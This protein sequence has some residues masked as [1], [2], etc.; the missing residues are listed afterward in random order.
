MENKDKQQKTYYQTIITTQQLLDNLYNTDWL[1]LDC[2]GAVVSDSCAFQAYTKD[3]IP[4][5][6]YC[7]INN[8]DD[9]S[10]ATKRFHIDDFFEET[11]VSTELMEHGFNKNSQIIIYDDTDNPTTDM[12]WLALKS[13]GIKNVAVLQGGY[14]AW[15]KN[16]YPLCGNQIK[17]I[18][19]PTD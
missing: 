8:H 5:A 2:R 11:L 18:L 15:N 3:H 4:T 6:H 12:F 14:D 10:K 1:I 9:T 13:M 16:K 19:K 7:S 17:P